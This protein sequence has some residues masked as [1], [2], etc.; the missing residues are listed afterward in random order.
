MNIMIFGEYERANLIQ[1]CIQ[2]AKFTEMLWVDKA[3]TR[4]DL[5]HSCKCMIYNVIIICK[6]Y[7]DAEHNYGECDA[8][9]LVYEVVKKNKSRI[10]YALSDG[11][12][13]KY[14][15]KLS[16]TG[17][18]SVVNFDRIIRENDTIVFVRKLIN[19]EADNR[20]LFYY[21]RKGR[22][23]IVDL[24]RIVYLMSING[25][26][27]MCLSNGEIVSFRETLKGVY[28]RLDTTK[29]VYV[30]RALLVNLGYTR[31]VDND[32]IE[33]K[34]NIFYVSRRRKSTL[35]KSLNRYRKTMLELI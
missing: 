20:D 15:N 31:V 1:E 14:G 29:Y 18:G 30:H 3:C 2:K 33:V 4:N 34:G 21:E 7:S 27:N 23:E 24:D 8:G 28:E 9:L 22:V 5:M 19:K 26:I 32:R 11:D 25:K 10:I 6:P 17:I 16:I 12:Y 35:I 13:Q